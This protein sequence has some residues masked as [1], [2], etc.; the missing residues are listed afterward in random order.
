MLRQITA[1]INTTATTA[2]AGL[3]RPSDL[4]AV[5][6]GMVIKINIDGALRNGEDHLHEWDLAPALNHSIGTD[7]TA[8][9]FM[10]RATINDPTKRSLR[11]LVLRESQLAIRRT[12]RAQTTAPLSA[13]SQDAS[14][15]P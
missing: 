4:R 10:G 13:S 15:N 1:G 3:S 2:T 8:R 11:G 12:Q 7:K 6:P 9:I 5:H 14:R